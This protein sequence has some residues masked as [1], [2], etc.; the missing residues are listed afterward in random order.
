MKKILTSLAILLWVS[1]LWATEGTTTESDSS[2]EIMTEV[3]KN[4]SEALTDFSYLLKEGMKSIK[5]ECDQL[6]NSDEMK[7]VKESL[8]ETMEEMKNR[9]TLYEY[10]SYFDDYVD[11][12]TVAGDTP[13]LSDKELLSKASELKD[14]FI[15]VTGTYESG[16]SNIIKLKGGIE[17]YLLRSYIEE[18]DLPKN[19]QPGETVSIYGKVLP[20]H[21]NR[22]KSVKIVDARFVVF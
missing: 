11:E 20:Y 18:A 7:G 21:P 9:K 1:P 12:F 16:D 4:V 6:K 13:F 15:V 19:L 5:D 22:S 14:Q 3:Q 8:N 17:V 2:N 10:S